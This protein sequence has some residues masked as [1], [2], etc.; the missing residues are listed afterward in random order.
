MQILCDLLRAGLTPGLEKCHWS[1]CKVLTWL[2]LEWDF[3][4]GGIRIIQ[5]RK[6]KLFDR[7]EL[8]KT[9][10]PRVT[11]REVS[12]IT[13]L[14]N[15]MHPVFNGREQL[16]SRFLQ[17][18]VNIRHEQFFNWDDHVMTDFTYL[19]KMIF[20]EIDFWLNEYDN[21][22]MRLFKSPPP[23]ILM[24]VDASSSAIAGIAMDI[25]KSDAILSIDTILTSF[26]DVGTS[27]DSLMNELIDVGIRCNSLMHTYEKCSAECNLQRFTD[28]YCENC[29]FDSSKLTFF[30]RM[31]SETEKKL[32]SNERE[33]L[34]G[35]ESVFGALPLIKNKNMTLHFDNLN[36][37]IIC[38]KG[39]SKIRLHLH[40]LQIDKFCLRNNIKINFVHI[41]R[42]LN[43]FAD[44]MSK[45]VDFEDYSVTDLFF[46][47]VCSSLRITPTIDR[48]ADNRNAKI[49]SFNSKSYCI[50]SMGVDAFNYNWAPPHINWLFPPPRLLEKTLNHLKDCKGIGL[51][52]TPEWKGSSFYAYYSSH[53]SHI[54]FVKKL[55]YSG[56]NVFNSGADKNSF[57]GPDF[58]CAVNLWLFDYSKQN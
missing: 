26:R 15:S 28:K 1:P 23:T 20:C 58:N 41:P 25:Q 7:I 31:L 14:L 13:G 39:S 16:H 54:N 45:I 57:F 50:G 38:E 2:G 19:N 36:A 3:H 11:Y 27:C 18:L 9:K 6:E 49:L 56:E 55:R 24:W 32:D 33:L 48:F 46:N 5:R 42:D 4:F 44:M 29:F 35:K 17:C 10:W 43:K 40:A 8:L 51:I 53:T 47:T 21:L 52:V 22:N 34:A 37:S 12:K 30:H